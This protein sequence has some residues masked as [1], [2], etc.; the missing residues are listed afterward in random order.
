M[1]ELWMLDSTRLVDCFFCQ[2]TLYRC[3][4]LWELCIAHRYVFYLRCK[5]RICIFFL[6]F[7]FAVLWAISKFLLHLNVVVLDKAADEKNNFFSFCCFQFRVKY[8]ANRPLD[9]A[10]IALSCISY[11]KTMIC[12]TNLGTL[13]LVGTF[14]LDSWSIFSTW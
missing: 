8:F 14:E 2:S 6:R 7:T 5:Y 4:P 9:I 10:K 12:L 1:Y 13:C 3:Y 11:W